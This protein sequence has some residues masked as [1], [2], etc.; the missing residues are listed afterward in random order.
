MCAYGK[1]YFFFFFNQRESIYAIFNEL[2]GN[3]IRSCSR[4]LV[5]ISSWLCLSVV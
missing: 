2:K 4:G 1:E 3:N 5:S